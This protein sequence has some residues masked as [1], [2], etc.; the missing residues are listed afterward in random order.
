MSS[1]NRFTK[2]FDDDACDWETLSRRLW[3]DLIL[4]LV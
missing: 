4:K 3:T 2:A 1:E